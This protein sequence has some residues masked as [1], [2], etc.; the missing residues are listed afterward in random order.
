MPAQPSHKAI[1][2][3]EDD[4]FQLQMLQGILGSDGYQ[5]QA[6]SN[7]TEALALLETARPDLILCDIG[8]PGMDG[9]AVLR[10]IR[11]ASQVPGVPFIFITGHHSQGAVIEGRRMGANDFLSKPIQREALLEAVYR[12][13]FPPTTAGL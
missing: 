1:L 2:L 7:G 9:F 5:V 3:I 6:V 10:H 13:L 11:R 12:A 8:M 4:A